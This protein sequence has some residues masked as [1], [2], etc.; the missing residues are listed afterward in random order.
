[1][2]I[3]HENHDHG[4]EAAATESRLTYAEASAQRAEAETDAL[5]T[6]IFFGSIPV[7]LLFV[8]LAVWVLQRR[9]HKK[10]HSK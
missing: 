7:F 2:R 5:I 9:K 4:A 10:R 8:A 6:G 1:M 3:A